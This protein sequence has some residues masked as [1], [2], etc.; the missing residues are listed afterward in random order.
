MV[1]LADYG[2]WEEDFVL[3]IGCGPSDPRVE[4]KNS[5]FPRADVLVDINPDLAPIYRDRRFL[6]ANV[7]AL[8]FQDGSFHFIWCAHILEH[9]F[10]PKTACEELMRV[11]KRGRIRTPS[12][13]K[14]MLHPLSYHRWLVTWYANTLIFEKKP[15]F[16]DSEKWK[17]V[18]QSPAAEAWRESVLFARGEGQTVLPQRFRET[19]FDWVE[20]F[21][22]EVFQ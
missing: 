2:I 7:E 16:L 13:Y 6:L 12:P 1:M 17:Q 3:D 22:V 9:I 18:V 15:A 19:I 5:A 21:Q 4:L 8:P 20:K 11:G 10:D 14:E